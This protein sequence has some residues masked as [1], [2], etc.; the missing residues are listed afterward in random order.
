MTSHLGR[1]VLPTLVIPAQAGI[2][3]FREHGR[4]ARAPGGVGVK[5]KAGR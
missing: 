1:R 4:P 3:T 5:M 2:Q